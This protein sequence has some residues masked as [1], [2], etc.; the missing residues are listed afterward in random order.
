METSK[1]F[2]RSVFFCSLLLLN[3]IVMQ[4]ETRY[5]ESVW[6]NISFRISRQ[7][8][9]CI[10]LIRMNFQLLFFLQ[11]RSTRS[12]IGKT[13]R[14]IKSK[15]KDHNNKTDLFEKIN[16]NRKNIAKSVLIW[17]LLIVSNLYFERIERKR[18]QTIVCND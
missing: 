16:I 2:F 3:F 6:R 15:K 10:L 18:I 5:F 13:S 11:V 8:S 17:N 12:A 9:N 4:H 7:V 1:C 14:S